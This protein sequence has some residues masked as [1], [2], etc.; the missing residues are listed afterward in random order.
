MQL[1]HRASAP[2]GASTGRTGLAFSS[3]YSIRVRR[4]AAVSETQQADT[5]VEVPTDEGEVQPIYIGFPKGD[6]APRTGRV[7]RVVVDDPR[8]YPT[9]DEW[10]G[11]W[12][13]GEAGLWELR[14]AYEK[15]QSRTKAPTG[16]A[17]VKYAKPTPKPGTKKI[18]VGFGK[19]EEEFKL[20]K[21]GEMGRV[22]YDNPEKYPSKDNVG[23]IVG[24]AG[25]FVG[26]EV[27]IKAFV[28]DGEVRLR[29]PGEPSQG[30][31]PLEATFLIL[32]G[33]GGAAAFTAR[34]YSAETGTVDTV[35]MQAALTEASKTEVFG[36]NAAAAAL[37]GLGALA[38]A[39]L[40]AKALDAVGE[41]VKEKGQAAAVYA[42]FAGAMVLGGYVV[43]RS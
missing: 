42:A 34:F 37:A 29:Q 9:K 38:A 10:T 40:V 11:G 17:L 25:G 5:D 2:L 1:C 8:K 28:R 26:G 35:A 27:G 33:S 36:V 15:E 12:A 43:L 16:S 4:V 6:Y 22:I 13:G 24:A 23:P 20:R 18:Y 30:L 7:G 41:T 3:K 31:S 14:E 19:S 39:S 21:S 32:L